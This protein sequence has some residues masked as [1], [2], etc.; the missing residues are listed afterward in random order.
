VEH[1]PADTAHGTGSIWTGTAGNVTSGADA[2]VTIPAGTLSDGW[3]IRWRARAVKGALRSDWTSWQTVTVTVPDFYTTTYAYDRNGRMVKQVDAN[4]NV[5]TFTYD[6][7]GRRTGGHDPDAGDSQQAYDDAGHLLWATDGKGQKV[8]YTYDDLGRKIATWSGEP[9]SGTKLAEWTYDTATKGKGLLASATRY[10]GGNAYTDAITSYDSMS[11]RTGSTLTVPSSEGLL[12][13]TYA[14]ATG[15]TL[16]GQVAT[17]TMPA[18]GG[19]PAE[20]VTSTYADLDLDLPH[21]MTSDVGGGFT[22]VNATAYSPTG[23]LTERTYGAGGKIKR[24]L[25]WDESTGWLRGVTT[26]TKA[27]TL[28]PV[29]TQDDRYTYDISGEI[30]RILDAVTATGT[31]PGQSECFTYDGLHRLSQAWTTTA[32]ACGTG[33]GSADNQGIDPYAQSFAYDGVGNI[34]GLTD[35]GQTA[36]YT[37]PQAGASAVRPNAVAS[38]TRPTGTDPYSYDGSGQLISREVGGMSSVFTWNELGELEKATVDGQDTTMVYGADG[39]R[40]IRRDPNGK[41]TLYLGL[42]EI[43]VK[44][45]T[46]T[47]KRYYITSDGATVA[48][49]IG[50]DGVTWLMAG[51]HG[52][53]QIAVDDNTGQV[54]RQRYLPF[55]R[56]RG[57]DSLPFTDHG[58]LGK[59]EDKSTGL[60]Y[61]SA[62]YYDP[63]IG[64]FAS[65][66]PV[67][68]LRLP[69]WANPYSYAGDNPVGLS[70]PTGLTICTKENYPSADDRNRCRDRETAKIRHASCVQARGEKQCSEGSSERD[71][72]KGIHKAS[73]SKGG[74][75][76]YRPGKQR[77]PTLSAAEKEA[78]K[79]HDEGKS[80]YD[81]KAYKRALQKQKQ[82]GKYENNRNSAKRDNNKRNNGKKKKGKIRE[83]GNKGEEGKGN[84]SHSDEVEDDGVSESSESSTAGDLFGTVLGGLV[85]GIAIGAAFVG[86]ALTG[87]AMA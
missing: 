84:K 37:Y 6:L 16:T 30:T 10:T 73:C 38:I 47:G 35:G 5:R 49:R 48:M 65:T 54:F 19:L 51:L 69:Q 59:T 82:G 40:L 78:L 61:L 17:Y 70:D 28:N 9:G 21:A 26:S 36:A 23:R 64:K 11:R 42:M 86:G 12:A 56:R 1:D 72:C 52:S 81:K 67:L 76:A 50:G 15:Y 58:F 68:D 46:I 45:Q 87:G 66:D 31:S 14:F 53:T 7:L 34:T 20:V 44:G 2:T 79:A 39:E 33:T 62:R 63:D 32:S 18:A 4:G 55:G 83:N 57:A 85:A 77:P 71:R 80:N 74:G 13:G 22:Y 25:E 43:E 41:T 75:A 29:I 8:S 60:D 24:A 3:K 27:D